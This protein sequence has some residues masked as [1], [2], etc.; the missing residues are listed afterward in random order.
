[1]QFTPMNEDQYAMRNVWPKGWYACEVAKCEE[2]KSKKGNSY[3]K[4]DTIIFNEKGQQKYVTTYLIA[5]GEAA[6]QLRSAA[7][8]FGLLEQYR[9]GV[10]APHDLIGRKAFAKVGIEHDD[11]GQYDPKNKI[12]DYRD[13]LPKKLAEKDN[14]TSSG[15]GSAPEL[16]DDIPF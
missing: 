5:E 9:A 16:N 2:G 6:W 13:Q 4:C 12:S 11:T 15:S 7:E 3:F 8:A 14:H 10:L 1:M